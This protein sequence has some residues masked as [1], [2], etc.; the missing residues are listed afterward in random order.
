VPGPYSGSGPQHAFVVSCS[1]KTVEGRGD[2]DCLVSMTRRDVTCA[3]ARR[4]PARGSDSPGQA[5]GAATRLR[6]SH[7]GVT[8][9]VTA[10]RGLFAGEAH[11]MPKPEVG[12]CRP[13]SP[14]A[15]E[16]HVS[17]SFLTSARS[18]QISFSPW[19]EDGGGKI[20]PKGL[21]A[22]TFR[23]I[24]SAAAGG[25]AQGVQRDPGGKTDQALSSQGG[26]T[27]EVTARPVRLAHQ[28][29]S[30]PPQAAEAAVA[31]G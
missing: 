2:P 27:A 11:D 8:A 4:G 3:W 17:R 31:K 1:R 24:R 25:P 15:G 30:P 19:L 21:L 12:Q 6:L 13:G 10:A 7:G 23:H 22:P 20:S 9:G 29:W 18:A 16:G 5:P 26:M 28:R 14:C